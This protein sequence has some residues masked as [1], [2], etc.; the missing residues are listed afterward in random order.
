MQSVQCQD[1]VRLSVRHGMITVFKTVS[2]ADPLS[3]AVELTLAGFQQDFP[4]LDGTRLAGVL[5]YGDVLKGLVCSQKR[6]VCGSSPTRSSRDFR[7]VEWA[8]T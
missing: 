7:R 3:R 2:P 8:T 4:V 5:T 6:T 1:S